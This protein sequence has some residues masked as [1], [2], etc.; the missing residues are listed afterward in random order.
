MGLTGHGLIACSSC[1]VLIVARDLAAVR[2]GV[3]D[4]RIGGIGRDVAALAAA[5]V[6]PIRAID[7]ALGARA[8]NSDG[9]VVLLRAVDVIR[10]I[11]CRW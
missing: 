5:D 10:E 9:R 7:A 4:L 11:G 1:G 3:H 8:R 2:T 6:V